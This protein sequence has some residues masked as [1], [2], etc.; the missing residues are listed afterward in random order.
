[1][2]TGT[3]LEMGVA[4][5][6]VIDNEVNAATKEDSLLLLLGS[7]LLLLLESSL[8]LLLGSKLEG[9]GTLLNMIG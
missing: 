5:F 6:V 9:G 7:S 8:L 2:I 3:K 4:G 1:M